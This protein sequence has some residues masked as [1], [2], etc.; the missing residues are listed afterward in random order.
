MTPPVSGA[1]DLTAPWLSDALATKV[2]AVRTEPVGTGQVSDSLRLFL[3]Y[4]GPTRLPATMVAKVPAADASSRAAAR[5]IRTYE[6][7]AHFYAQIADR[8]DA[9]VPTCYFAAYAPEPDEY[10]VLLEDLAPALP[11]DQLAGVTTE[12]A[13]AAIDEMAALHAAGWDDPDLAALPWLNR[14]DA[15]SAAFTASMVTGLYDGFKERYGADLHPDVLTLIEDFLPAI[16]TYLADREGPST[17]FHGDFRADNLL[18][19]GPRAA[20]LD[21]QTCAYAPG[22]ADLAYFLGSSLP[23]DARRTCEHTLVERYHK[24]LTTRGVTLTWDDCWNAYRRHAFHGIVMSIGASMIVERTPRGDE[25]FRTMTTRHAHHAR[26][27]DSLKLT[28]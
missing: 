13:A 16:G 21:W 2:T 26:D 14:H 1:G 18:F 25:M 22:P 7:E 10:T 19:G 27:L 28:G 15:D 3:T 5:A 23:T 17:L 24:A 4:A 6:V 12:D 20:V 8:L 9:G 11:G